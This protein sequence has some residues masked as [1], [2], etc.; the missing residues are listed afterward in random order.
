VSWPLGDYLLECEKRMKMIPINS[1][2]LIDANSVE[3]KKLS[4]FKRGLL[5][6]LV[7]VLVFWLLL[8]ILGAALLVF[9]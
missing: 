6:G 4:P 3:P 8:F 5:V 2:D 1:D 9:H 7:V